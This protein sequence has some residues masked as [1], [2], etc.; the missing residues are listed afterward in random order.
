MKQFRL[1]ITHP[2]A[3]TKFFGHW[4]SDMSKDELMQAVATTIQMGEFLSLTGENQFV[5]LPAEYIKNNC[6]LSFQD[7]V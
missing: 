5:M 2:A 6:Y 7:K 3:N 1:V 4:V